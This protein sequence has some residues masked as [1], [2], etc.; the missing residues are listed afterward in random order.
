MQRWHHLILQNVPAYL[1]SPY[2]AKEGVL[3][4]TAESGGKFTRF[5]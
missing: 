5:W 1:R 4:G 3:S 2:P